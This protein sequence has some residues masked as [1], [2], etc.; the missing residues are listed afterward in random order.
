MKLGCSHKT[1]IGS[2]GGLGRCGGC[3][4]G[5]PG[6]WCGLKRVW[7]LLSAPASYFGP[8]TSFRNP[9]LTRIYAAHL[10]RF[11]IVDRYQRPARFR[12]PLSF[13]CSCPVL[14]CFAVSP[15]LVSSPSSRKRAILPI[16]SP[17][18]APA[19]LH[20]LLHPSVVW[21]LCRLSR[22]PQFN[23]EHS[24]VSFFPDIY[25]YTLWCEWLNRNCSTSTTLPSFFP[26]YTCIRAARSRGHIIDQV[27]FSE[28]SRTELRVH[29]T[30]GI[31]YPQIFLEARAIAGPE[32]H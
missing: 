10:A 8:Y 16:T 26:H 18:P 21:N 20:P 31:S 6:R 19:C 1:C 12:T 27:P 23:A 22:V 11:V 9:G 7:T 29:L 25:P 28:H 17:L 2:A 24:S 3:A 30:P 14:S 4:G 15:R 13:L 5:G 32:P